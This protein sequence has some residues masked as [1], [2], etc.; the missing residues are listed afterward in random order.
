MLGFTTISFEAFWAAYESAKSKNLLQLYV[1]PEAETRIE[2]VE[3]ESEQSKKIR[4]EAAQAAAEAERRRAADADADRRLR[5]QRDESRN[6]V[7]A[8][9]RQDQ[10][11]ENKNR[12]ME[13]A[14][15]AREAKR[16]VDFSE[17]MVNAATLTGHWRQTEISRIYRLFPEYKPA[18]KANSAIGTPDFPA[19]AVVKAMAENCT[20]LSYLYQQTADTIRT[21]RRDPITASKI[22]KLEKIEQNARNQQL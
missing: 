12:I 18:E 14:K 5:K 20:F 3:V 8:S 10:K 1:A 11:E 17:L 4:A 19:D 7:N 21:W 2:Y 16:Y 22:A 6:D 13:L 9:W 15:S